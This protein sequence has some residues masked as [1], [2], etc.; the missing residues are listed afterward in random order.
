MHKDETNFR[1]DQVATMSLFSPLVG[2]DEH[3]SG[4]M[5]ASVVREKRAQRRNR[6][7]EAKDAFATPQSQL[8]ARNHSFGFLDDCRFCTCEI[9][10][11]LVI[12]ET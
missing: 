3:G 6:Q 12:I 2:W 8:F 1:S 10:R 11:L 9:V 5:G 4:S 7:Q